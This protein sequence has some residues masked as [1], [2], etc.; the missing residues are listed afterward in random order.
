MSVFFNISIVL[1]QKTKSI[2][3]LEM[4]ECHNAESFLTFAMLQW[5][6]EQIL[7]QNL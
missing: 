5:F 6:K 7:R 1:S 4:A 3:E 2:K